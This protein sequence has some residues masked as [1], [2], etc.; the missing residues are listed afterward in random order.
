[1]S[2][3]KAKTKHDKIKLMTYIQHMQQSWREEK[4]KNKKND[5]C[6]IHNSGRRSELQSRKNC[7]IKRLRL[8][9]SVGFLYTGCPRRKGQYSGRS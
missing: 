5:V 7:G 3:R 6:Q 9:F 4:E 1:M 2:Y 8:R